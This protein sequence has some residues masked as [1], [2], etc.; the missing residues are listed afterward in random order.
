[1]K[2]VTSLSASRTAQRV[3]DNPPL[4]REKVGLTITAWRRGGRRPANGQN[5]G[6]DDAALRRR[7]L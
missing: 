3:V 2:Y 7:T 1:V 4:S 5:G 6:H